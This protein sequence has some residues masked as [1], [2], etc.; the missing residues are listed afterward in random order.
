MKSIKLFA[1]CAMGAVLASCSGKTSDEKRPESITADEVNEISYLTGY[2]FGQYI[3]GNDMGALSLAQI[4]KGIKDAIAG[5]EIEED[6]FYET[7]NGYMEKRSA[8]KLEINKKEAEEFFA[9]NAKEADIQTTPSG[10]QYKVVRKGNGKKP[11]A[12]DTVEVNYEGKLLNGDV[13]D[14]S[15]ER[16]ETA[17]FGL[18]Q[19]IKGWSEGMQYCEEGGEIMLWIPSDLAYGD[20]GAGPQIGPGAA[21]QFKVE[22]N[23]ITPAAPAAEAET[24]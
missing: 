8:A 2:S 13:F 12:N 21:L 6:K 18:N 11:G 19:V 22:L 23:K 20:N 24:K 16:G 5:V 7:M 9:K 14:S 3:K 17:T 15:Y 10:I 1:L 4:N